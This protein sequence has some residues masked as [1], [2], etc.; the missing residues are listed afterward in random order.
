MIGEKAADMIL[1]DLDIELPLVV[2]RR[3][4]TQA[5]TLSTSTDTH[6]NASADVQRDKERMATAQSAG[7][8][9]V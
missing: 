9:V 8:S 4:A 2:Q 3:V 6:N 5:A 1:A 7:N